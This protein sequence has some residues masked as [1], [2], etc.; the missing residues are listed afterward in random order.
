[1]GTETNHTFFTA[2][3][4]MWCEMAAAWKEDTH[5]TEKLEAKKRARNNPT[6]KSSEDGAKVRK[7]DYSETS[8][9]D[10]LS[11]NGDTKDQGTR[12]QGQSGFSPRGRGNFRGNSRGNF[13]ADNFRGN[14]RGGGFR[15]RG[16]FRGRGRGDFRGG[17][18]GNFRGRGDFRGR[19]RGGNF[20]GNNDGNNFRGRGRG[21]GGGNPFHPP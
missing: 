5:V 20:Q 3:G 4:D 11:F 6:P 8:H 19:G 1:M 9:A 15:G 14:S 18:R 21:R 12:D 16:D 7:M 17:P 13:Q 2:M 10:V